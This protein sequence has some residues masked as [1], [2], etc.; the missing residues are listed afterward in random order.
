MLLDAIDCTTPVRG[1]FGTQIMWPSRARL[2][3]LL[4][5]KTSQLWIQLWGMSADRWRVGSQVVCTCRRDFS[6]RLTLVA[7]ILS[8]VSRALIAFNHLVWISLSTCMRS[9]LS[10]SSW[11][12]SSDG[13]TLSHLRTHIR[14]A[15]SDSRI[16]RRW[17]APRF[18]VPRGMFPLSFGCSWFPWSQWDSHIRRSI[19]G[20]FTGPSL[21]EELAISECSF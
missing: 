2:Y 19:L 1:Q 16:W 8:S 3:I 18:W 11:S 15:A 13:M 4:P 6:S 21:L 14:W 17:L 5:T 7:I 10:S 9:S 12:S 20:G